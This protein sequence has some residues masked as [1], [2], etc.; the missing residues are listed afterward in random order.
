MSIAKLDGLADRIKV[1][2]DCWLW[3][4][5]TSSGGYGQLRHGRYVHRVVFETLVGPIPAR[6]HLDHL[7]RNRACCNPVH[8]E[9][10]SP[11]E[12][13]MRAP[14]SLAAIN[15]AKTHCPAGHAYAGANLIRTRCGR[16]Q[17][18]ACTAEASAR[19][20]AKLKARRQQKRAAQSFEDHSV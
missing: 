13:L 18:R 9:A 19:H 4:G 8:L 3:T 10:V 1:V 12:N 5:E 11:R 16:R 17:C 20:K 7:C 14:N 6:H 2:G 15:A